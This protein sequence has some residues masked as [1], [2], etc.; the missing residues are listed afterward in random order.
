[1]DGRHSRGQG[2]SR[3]AATAAS[4]LDE[5]AAVRGEGEE[6]ERPRDKFAA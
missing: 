5:A 4:L 1:M 3:K 2:Q 6:W